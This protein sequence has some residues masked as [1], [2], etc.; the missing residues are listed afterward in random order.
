MR[1]VVWVHA[2]MLSLTHPALRIEEGAPA[3]FVF[4]EALLDAMQ[5]GLKRV[6][7]LYECL[8]EM[9]V[10]IRRGVVVDE[11][12]AFAAE[13]KAERI[14]T[15]SSVSPRFEVICRDIGKKLPMGSRL[16]V[17]NDEPFVVV[18]EPLD[19]RRFSSYWQAVK[20]DVLGK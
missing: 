6:V 19:L 7:F 4:D 15:G 3:V 8:L 14:V 12:L 2:D 13:H 9:P 17:V 1:A 16:E 10:S 18:K 5:I 11:V 20:H